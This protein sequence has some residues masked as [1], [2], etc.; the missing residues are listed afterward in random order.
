MTREYLKWLLDKVSLNV[1]WENRYSLL[2]ESLS[3]CEFKV[4]V[5][6]DENLI[7]H[8]EDLREDYE[9]ET[10]EIVE[11]PVSLLEV[12]VVLC[13]K[14]ED[15]MQS[16]DGI[17]CE[18]WFDAMLVSSQ[19]IGYDN[20]HFVNRIDIVE[21]IEAIVDR[22]YFRDGYGGLFYIPI[23]RKDIDLREIE[24]WYQLL[25]YID[26]VIDVVEKE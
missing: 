15:I 14:A 24:L 9:D 22:K 6:R 11:G 3:E 19:L 10:G 16:F 18:R 8:S 23:I 21:R 1:R 2:M 17:D 5:D 4:L 26:Y 13:I 7:A 20:D 25:W 12:M